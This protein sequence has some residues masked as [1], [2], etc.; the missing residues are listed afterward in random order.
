MDRDDHGPLAGQAVVGDDPV[1]AATDPWDRVAGQ[2]AADDPV[3][4]D[5]PVAGA[6]P[7]EARGSDQLV[8]GAQAARAGPVDSG[9][10]DRVAPVR[11]RRSSG[12]GRRSNAMT[13][14]RAPTTGRRNSDPGR[15][16]DAGIDR[17]RA[18]ASTDLD[19]PQGRRPN[20]LASRHARASSRIAPSVRN[21][22]LRIGPSMTRMTS[23]VRSARD[24][25]WSGNGR[26]GRPVR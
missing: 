12:H 10:P 13:T 21:S 9:I 17:H 5:D 19:A 4:V 26:P 23:R 7:V 22:S 15:R 11:A 14:R 18:R 8:P 6:R 16:Q 3:A 24:R 20:G 2:A 1:V 25:R